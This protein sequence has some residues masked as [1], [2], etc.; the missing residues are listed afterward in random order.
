MNGKERYVVR[1]IGDF[2]VIY[3]VGMHLIS[4]LCEDADLWYLCREEA[5]GKRGRPKKYN[6]KINIS[7]IDK[8]YFSLVEQTQGHSIYS[9]IVYSKS[10]KRNIHLTYVVYNLK[11]GKRSIK[12]YFSTDIALCSQDILLFYQT[13]FQIDFL[14]RD[15][16]Q[17][18]GP[19]NGQARGENKVNFHFNASLTVINIAKVED[20]LSIPREVRKQFSIS[21]I[22]IMNHNRLLMDRFFN[23]FGI[24]PNKPKNKEYV[25][26]LI[27]YGTIAA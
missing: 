18:T 22:K 23:V 25:K 14:Y 6:D 19:C 11:S 4:R 27:Y 12:L 17:F 13:R 9:A 20:W 15:G 16:K 10:H 24:D 7:D 21:D 5:T 8:G 3:T 1:Y 2:F 26:E